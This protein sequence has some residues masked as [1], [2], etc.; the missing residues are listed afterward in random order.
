MPAPGGGSQR[1]GSRPARSRTDPGPPRIEGAVNAQRPAGVGERTG[2]MPPSPL[3][4]TAEVAAMLRLSEQAIR[5]MVTVGEIPA[6]KVGRKLRFNRAQV[7][8]IAGLEP[9]DP[10][11]WPR[12]LTRPEAAAFLRLSP[13]T[14]TVLARDKRIRAFQLGKE[15]RFSREAIE[16]LIPRSVPEAGGH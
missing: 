10:P 6:A 8:T 13:Q 2:R 7:E 15:W 1:G 12:V 16:A 14:V 5:D 11:E 9:G 4:T 3:M